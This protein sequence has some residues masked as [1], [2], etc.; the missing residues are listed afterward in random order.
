LVAKPDDPIAWDGKTLRGARTN[1]NS[2]PHLLAFCTHHSHETLLQVAVDE[3]MNEIPVAQTL[4]PTLPLRGRVRTADALH[5]QREFM[6]LLMNSR[7]APSSS[8][9]TISQVCSPLIRILL[10]RMPSA[11]KQ[12]PGI[13][14]GDALK[15]AAFA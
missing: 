9:K 4:L 1:T 13:G 12:G 11:Y 6:R 7:L 3:K 10:I 15:S 8:S 14:T 5:T 2:V